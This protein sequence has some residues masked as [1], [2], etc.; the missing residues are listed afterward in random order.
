MITV[1]IE[2]AELQRRLNAVLEALGPT[3]FA[4][5]LEDI[6]QDLEEGTRTRISSGLN[7]HRRRF[8]PNTEVTLS[9]KR[10]GKPLIDTGTFVSSRLFHYVS[11]SEVTIGASGVQAAVLQFGAR[12]GQFGQG[13]TRRF[14]IPWGDIP[15]RPYLPLADDGKDLAP[16]ARRDVLT[17]IEEY[18]ESAGQ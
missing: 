16:V 2:D 11:G 7:W 14:A 18:I 6:G 9:R 10:G 4:R 13:T 5:V 12:K 1:Q 15:P 17:T 3:H 8:A